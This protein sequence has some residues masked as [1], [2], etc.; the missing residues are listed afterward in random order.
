MDLSNWLWAAAQLALTIAYAR[1]VQRNR[2][3]REKI[4]A[5]LADEG[6]VDGEAEAY[7]DETLRMTAHLKMPEPNARDFAH[8]LIRQK[9]FRRAVAHAELHEVYVEAYGR[10]SDG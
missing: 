1:E 6:H 2:K 5:L 4:H 3:Y 8:G 10:G 9:G 7:I